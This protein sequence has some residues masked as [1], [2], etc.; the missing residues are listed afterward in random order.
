MLCVQRRGD[1]AGQ[2]TLYPMTCTF[3]AAHF[4]RLTVFATRLW[5]GCGTKASARGTRTAA[6]GSSWP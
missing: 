4:R 1:G 3:A 6:L 2:A 5:N